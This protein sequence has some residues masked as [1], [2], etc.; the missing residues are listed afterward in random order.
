MKK[1]IIPWEQD[2]KDRNDNPKEWHL[3]FES[4]LPFT[5]SSFFEVVVNLE[6]L[7]SLQC[8]GFLVC[9]LIWWRLITEF[10]TQL[11]VCVLVVLCSIKMVHLHF[12]LNPLSARLH[13][14]GCPCYWRV[15]YNMAWFEVPEIEEVSILT[16]S[17]NIHGLQRTIQTRNPE[18]WDKMLN[19]GSNSCTIANLCVSYTDSTTFSGRHRRY[20]ETLA[21][22]SFSTFRSP[23]TRRSQFVYG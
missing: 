10:F 7:F 3:E 14:E 20:E 19:F 2:A 18:W 12:M 15:R 9:D 8:Y 13:F 11:S 21:F 6:L 1:R 16:S 17:C 5:F 23:I 22:E 4:E